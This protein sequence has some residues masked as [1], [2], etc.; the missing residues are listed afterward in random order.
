M[1]RGLNAFARGTAGIGCTTEPD[2]AT[3]A[4]GLRRPL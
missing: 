2:A 4:R 3:A 1:V